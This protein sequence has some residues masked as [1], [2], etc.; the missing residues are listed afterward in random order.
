MCALSQNGVHD[1]LVISLLDKTTSP[2]HAPF[3]KG[4]LMFT[5]V[6]CSRKI[7]WRLMFEIDVAVLSLRFLFQIFL[8]N[9]VAF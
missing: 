3:A 7:K 9:P 6:K 5:F 4:I 1:H 8:F 2:V